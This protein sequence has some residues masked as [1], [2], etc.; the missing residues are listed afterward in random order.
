MPDWTPARPNKISN[1]L[2]A[3]IDIKLS[4]SNSV[5]L[6]INCAPYRTYCIEYSEKLGYEWRPLITNRTENGIIEYKDS[7]NLAP[8]RFYR[9][10]LLP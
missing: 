10:F 8:I 4:D 7:I 9:A 2:P 3:V 5:L 1:P 6:K